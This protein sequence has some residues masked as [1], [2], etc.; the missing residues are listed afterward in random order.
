MTDRFIMETQPVNQP[1]ILEPPVTTAPAAVPVARKPDS[2]HWQDLI[3]AVPI[4]WGF[5]LALGI[6]MAIGGLAGGMDLEDGPTPALLL[7]LTVV[8]HLFAVV[9]MWLFACRKY[10]RSFVEA[11]ALRYPGVRAVVAS[12]LIGLAGAGVA[13]L[14]MHWFGTGESLMSRMVATPTGLA[15]VIALAAFAPPFE[16]L[17]YRGFIFPVLRD[18]L[19]SGWSIVMVSVWFTLLHVFQLAGDWA[20]LPVI[21]AVAFVWTWQRH[22]YRSLVPSLICHWT[23][24]LCAVILP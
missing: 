24:N 2:L 10:G 7:A 14:V 19:G 20:A 11:F 15:C 23:Y 22:H 4:L 6:V 16:E 13:S 17:Y 5:E 12:V 9:V 21:L 3:V 18:V 1:P 8:S